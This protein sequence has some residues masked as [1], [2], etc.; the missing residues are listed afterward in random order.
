MLFSATGLIILAGCS[1]LG[2]LSGQGECKLVGTLL[3]YMA[4]PDL[5]RRDDG[6]M[7]ASGGKSGGTWFIMGVPNTLRVLLLLLLLFCQQHKPSS[8]ECSNSFIL[9]MRPKVQMEILK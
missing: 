8:S 7:C 9:G 2:P 1:L 5:G 3:P 4:P 6:A